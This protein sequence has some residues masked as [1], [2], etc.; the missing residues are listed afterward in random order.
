MNGC[1]ED[2]LLGTSPRADN[3]VAEEGTQNARHTNT[4]VSGSHNNV[5][6][7][8]L[9]C[10]HTAITTIGGEMIL[11]ACEQLFQ[12]S[13]IPVEAQV[14]ERMVEISK[15]ENLA[16]AELLEDF[17]DNRVKDR[18]MLQ[19]LCVVAICEESELEKK[20]RNEM[21]DTL[22]EKESTI[23]S[24]QEHAKKQDI[25]V[26]ELT[27]KVDLLGREA[28]MEEGESSRTGEKAQ[29][30]RRRWQILADDSEYTG[31][32]AL[33]QDSSALAVSRRGTHISSWLS[34]T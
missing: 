30:M 34:P 17:L 10:V 28:R 7:D 11:N 8:F 6:S 25:L 33:L 3:Y 20:K 19:R 13:Q 29:D 31:D 4:K 2:Q 15:E 24:L 5:K 9:Q 21:V 12:V 22:E 18:E 23:A 27:K 1:T 16:R 32:E 26:Q 14:E